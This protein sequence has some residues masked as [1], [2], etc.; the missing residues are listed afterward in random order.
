M[1]P[2]RIPSWTLK[3]G[4]YSTPLG[5]PTWSQKRSYVH[6]PVVPYPCMYTVLV[7][8]RAGLRAWVLPRDGYTGGCTGWVIPGH[9]TPS[10]AARGECRS[11]RS[12]PVGPCKGPEWWGSVLGR[13]CGPVYAALTTHS[14]CPAAS[15]ARFAVRPARDGTL[16]GSA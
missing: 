7:D 14:S 16:R 4:R 13:P 8:V 9:G 6:V 12:G 1:D 2:L 5:S 10:H 3:T 15:G 11:Q